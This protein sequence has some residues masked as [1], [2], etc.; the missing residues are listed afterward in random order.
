M[1]ALAVTAYTIGHFVFVFTRLQRKVEAL[2]KRSFNLKV[3][4]TNPSLQLSNAKVD[5]VTNANDTIEITR[6]SYGSIW[7]HHE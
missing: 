4:G 7:I 5:S 6:I 3:H 2:E 1:T